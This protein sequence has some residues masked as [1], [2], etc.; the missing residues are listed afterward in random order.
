MWIVWKTLFL[1]TWTKV[2]NLMS[3]YEIMQILKIKNLHYIIY[4]IQVPMKF[5][6]QLLTL[7]KV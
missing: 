2:Q 7:V 3:S 1:I 5:I 6:I 4:L